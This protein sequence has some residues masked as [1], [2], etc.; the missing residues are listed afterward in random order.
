MKLIITFLM[1][2]IFATSIPCQVWAEHQ[3]TKI[4][5]L[6]FQ[7]IGK[8]SENSDVGKTILE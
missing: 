2:F 3:K 4:A 6:D 8:G 1:I 7:V 5:I